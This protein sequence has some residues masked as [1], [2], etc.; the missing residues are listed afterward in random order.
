MV[1]QLSPVIRADGYHILSDLT[2]VPDLY[3]QMGPTLRRLI[4]GHGKEPSALS[5]KARVIVTL[6]VLIVVPVLLSMMLGAILLLP[7][8]ATS[9]WDGGHQI[10]AAIPHQVSDGQII[11]VLASIV[12][13]LALCL[14]LL[15]SGLVAQ[16]IVRGMVAK[17]R[18][19]RRGS[20]IRGHCSWW[21]RRD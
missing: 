18:A 14:P 15:G 4:P 19:W 17:G 2:G 9:A 10:A 11:D 7:R 13:L 12:R 1:K 16:K 3:A 5:G 8:V 6:W 21:L 20:R